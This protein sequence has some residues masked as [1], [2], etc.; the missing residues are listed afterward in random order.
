MAAGEGSTS[1][2]LLGSDSL[3]SSSNSSDLVQNGVE[4]TFNWNSLLE[5]ENYPKLE[6]S[7]RS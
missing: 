2:L 5:V 6:E 3:A 7:P 4:N 1:D